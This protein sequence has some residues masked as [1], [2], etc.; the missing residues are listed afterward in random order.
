MSEIMYLFAVLLSINSVCFELDNDGSKFCNQVINPE[1]KN[2]K[3]AELNL[4][5]FVSV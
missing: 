1:Y 3:A 4:N 5:L 2:A